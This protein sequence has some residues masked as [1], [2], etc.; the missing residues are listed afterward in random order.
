MGHSK[1]QKSTI[2]YSFAIVNVN[3]YFTSKGLYN[4]LELQRLID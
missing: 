1:T 3:R 4:N 2:S